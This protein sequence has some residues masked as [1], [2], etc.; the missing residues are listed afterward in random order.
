MKR[1]RPCGPRIVFGRPLT[2]VLLVFQLSTASGAQDKPSSDLDQKANSFVGC[3]ELHLG[4]WWPWGMGED[5]RFATP[6]SRIE[7]TLG[8]GT[9]GFEKDELLIRQ[10]SSAQDA[11]GSAFWVPGDHGKVLLVWTNGFSGVSLR[12]AKNGNTLKGWAH[13]HFD[14]FRPPHVAHVVARPVECSS[15]Q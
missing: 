12:L 1:L 8:R 9:N 3:Y 10:I 11:R 5:T 4:R 2:A 13:A 7:L 15:V 6:P 14:F